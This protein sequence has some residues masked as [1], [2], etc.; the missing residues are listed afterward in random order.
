[1][2]ATS[3]DE[4]GNKKKLGDYA[5]GYMWGTLGIIYDANCSETIREDVKS[6]DVFWDSNYKNL[7]SIKNSMRDTFVVGLCD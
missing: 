2:E 6:W 1:M 3:L 4:N 5:A 7:I